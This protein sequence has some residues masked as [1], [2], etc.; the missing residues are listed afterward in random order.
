MCSLPVDAA[1]ADGED[2][3]KSAVSLHAQR[4]IHVAKRDV[5][6]N[7]EIEGSSKSKGIEFEDAVWRTLSAIPGV[8]VSRQPET[9]GSQFRPDFLV[10]LPN[11]KVL[12]EVKTAS[13]FLP[14]VSEQ[15]TAALDSYGADEALVVVPKETPSLERAR[16][17]DDR[18][19]LLEVGG[20]TDFI[21]NLLRD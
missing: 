10:T 15:I 1:L 16:L 19:S 17:G 14:A 18:L 8:V 6:G 9:P 3:Q 7:L 2:A 4:V 11:H 13:E 12:V 21:R 5:V 20:V